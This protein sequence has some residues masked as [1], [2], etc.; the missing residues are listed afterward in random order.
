MASTDQVFQ[1]INLGTGILAA[2]AA[3][4]KHI[5]AGTVTNQNT[6]GYKV[7]SVFEQIVAAEQ[8]LAPVVQAAIPTQAAPTPVTAPTVVTAFGTEPKV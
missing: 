8:L 6:V 5:A 2:I 4:L 1:D 7:A 3:L